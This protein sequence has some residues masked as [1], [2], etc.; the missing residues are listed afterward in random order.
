MTAD[1]AACYLSC[2]GT[3]TLILFLLDGL[4]GAELL[5]PKQKDF[6]KE[7][8]KRIPQFRHLHFYFSDEFIPR[9]IT[10]KTSKRSQRKML[11]RIYNDIEAYVVIIILYTKPGR[12]RRKVL[13]H[14]HILGCIIMCPLCSFVAFQTHR[15]KVN[16][17]AFMKKDFVFIFK[18]QQQK[19][20][21]ITDDIF[22]TTLHKVCSTTGLLRVTKSNFK[23][24]ALTELWEAAVRQV[25]SFKPD[26]RFFLQLADHRTD[27]HQNYLI[28]DLVLIT[29]AMQ[30][31]RRANLDL[32]LSG[33]TT[34]ER[35]QLKTY[36]LA[37]VPFQVAH[38]P[39]MVTQQGPDGLDAA[40]L[41]SLRDLLANG[42]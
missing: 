32:F 19:F 30:E 17:R 10:D 12:H 2:L 6:S 24:G 41:Q 4:R 15:L 18:G 14:F 26:L 35:R 34:T 27:Y 1:P 28:P 21:P 9:R 16:S 13:M 7:Q 22:A 37:L 39:R 5:A 40:K 3:V 33:I 31:V 38:T 25:I 20:Y 11:R 23:I 42:K 8:R 36:I 29:Q